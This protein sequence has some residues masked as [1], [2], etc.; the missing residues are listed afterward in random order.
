MTDPTFL[1]CIDVDGSL[2]LF[3]PGRLDQLL[4]LAAIAW[5]R[6]LSAADRHRRRH[7][8][9]LEMGPDNPQSKHSHWPAWWRRNSGE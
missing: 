6:L 9:H 2:F 4:H 3:S 7:A 8:D 5:N 1:P